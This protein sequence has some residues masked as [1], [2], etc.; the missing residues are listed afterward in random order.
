MNSAAGPFCLAAD[1]ARRGSD[2]PRMVRGTCSI[3]LAA[4]SLPLP[5]SAG[6]GATTLPPSV[7]IPAGSTQ[8]AA[9]LPGGG[10]LCAVDE[11][12]ANLIGAA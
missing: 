6:C 8:V 7:T 12:P 5:A 4:V 9:S 1:A 10:G 2:A 11:V 3:D